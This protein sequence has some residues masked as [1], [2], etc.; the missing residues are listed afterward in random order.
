MTAETFLVTYLGLPAGEATFR[1][2][3]DGYGF[4]WVRLDGENVTGEDFAT[5]QDCANALARELQAHY[6][7]V[8]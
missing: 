6:R 4:T 8:Q 5:A 2:T 1:S 3:A 7:S